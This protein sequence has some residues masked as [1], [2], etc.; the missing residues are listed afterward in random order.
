MSNSL[1]DRTFWVNTLIAV[2]RPV[3]E[4]L[5]NR[6]LKETMPVEKQPGEGGL[7]RHKYTYLEA[8]GRTLAGISPWLECRELEE[9]E[10]RLRRQY[11]EWARHAIDAATDPESADFLNFSEG[12]QP[13]VD[14]AFLSHAFLRAPNELWSKLEPRVKANVV[15]CLQATRSRKPHYNNWLLFSAM[16]ETALYKMG[17]GWDRMRV[18]YAIKEHQLW[19]KGDGVYGDGPWFHWDY[20]NSF[21]IQPMLL[22][23]LLH[24]GEEER[25]WGKLYPQTLAIARRFAVV[26]ERMIAPDGTFPP[27]GRS[28]AYR[29]GAFQHLGQ[30]ALQHHLPDELTPAQ[31]RCALN[32][33]IKRT[34]EAPGT[35]DESGWLRIGLCGSQP[36]IGESYIST[37][38]LYL[39]TTAFLPLGLSPNDEFWSAPSQDWTSKKVWAGQDME[40]DHALGLHG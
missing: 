28:L 15:R 6:K 14:A 9:E 22:D 17:A 7:D 21:V 26:Q 29:G 27:I 35:F 3:L 19:Y 24:L 12:G 34:M 31:V 36:S 16:I 5:A 10:E 4:A 2:A 13:I 39:C 8:L 18:D 37:G 1:S 40:C 38:S 23:I 30:M 11:S 32:A 25:D 33:M 20:Y